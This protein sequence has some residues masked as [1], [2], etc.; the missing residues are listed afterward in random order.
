MFQSKEHA[1][2]R[3][4]GY[5]PLNQALN[6][7]KHNGVAMVFALKACQLKSLIFRVTEFACI[8]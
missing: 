2:R 7:E 6:L 8:L 1:S 4:T 3:N 5:I